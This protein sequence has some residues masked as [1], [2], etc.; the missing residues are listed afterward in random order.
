M[1]TGAFGNVSDPFGGLPSISTTAPKGADFNDGDHGVDEERGAA[2]YSYPIAVPPGRSGMQPSLALT[3]SSQAPLRGGIAVGWTFFNF[4][5]VEV[6]RSR[7]T[8]ELHY[9][10]NGARLVEVDD[11]KGSAVAVYRAAYDAS[12]T[13]WERRYDVDLGEYWIARSLNGSRMEFKKNVGGRQW[14]LTSQIDAYGNRVDYDWGDQ[15][16][17]WANAPSGTPPYLAYELK[18][19]LY[20]ANENTHIAPFARVTFA[21]SDPPRQ[22]G[23]WIP[24][25]AQL[26]WEDGPTLSNTGDA[27]G[28]VMGARQLDAVKTWVKDA[29][30]PSGWRDVQT[31]SLTY[32]F[33]D[34]ERGA[35]LRYLKY[36]DVSARAPCP[37]GTSCQAT[38][39]VAPR[40]TL[41]YGRYDRLFDK[42]HQVNVP[43]SAT[44]PIDSGLAGTAAGATTGF[45]DIDGDGLRDLVRMAAVRDKEDRKSNCTIL[46][47]KGL[48]DGQF[49]PETP[50]A[51]GITIPTMDWL[52]NEL[53]QGGQNSP[54]LGYD[55]NSQEWVQERCTLTGQYALEFRQ[56][57]LGQLQC[58]NEY[59]KIIGYRF[60]DFDNDGQIDLLTTPWRAMALDAPTSNSL[61]NTGRIATD[62][63]CG[64]GL[65]CG[66]A[67]SCVGGF[68]ASPGAPPPTVDCWDCGD[69]GGD[70]GGPGPGHTQPSRFDPETCGEWGTL[71]PP[72]ESISNIDYFVW[73]LLTHDGD[74]H[75]FIYATT[76]HSQLPLPPPGQE[77]LVE[78][79]NGT[80]P[81]T[82]QTL[83]D[84]DDDGVLDILATPRDPDSTAAEEWRTTRV[85]LGAATH[86]AVGL[87]DP[88]MWFRPA[89]FRK[90]SYGHM[91][92]TPG[93][94]PPWNDKPTSAELYSNS[95]IEDINGDGLKDLVLR[96][97]GRKLSYYPNTGKRFAENLIDLGFDVPVQRTHVDATWNSGNLAPSGG[98]RRT[99]FQLFDVDADGRP[100]LVELQQPGDVVRVRYNLGD[101]FSGLKE[102]RSEWRAVTRPVAM[103]EG[104][105]MVI[106]D[107]TD[108]DGDGLPD[109]QG[110]ETISQ[111]PPGGGAGFVNPSNSRLL[112]WQ[113]DDYG[114][115]PPRLLTTIDNGR[116][117]TTYYEYQPNSKLEGA[118]T[119]KPIFVVTRVATVASPSSP[120]ISTT[121]R[122]SRPQY[123]AH[124]VLDPRSTTTIYDDETRAMQFQ[125]F[126]EVE[127][128]GSAPDGEGHGTDVINTYEYRADGRGYLVRQRSYVWDNGAV[129]RRLLHVGL[130]SWFEEPL[131]DGRVSTVRNVVADTRV[132]L[133]SVEADCLGDHADGNFAY[134]GTSTFVRSVLTNG[135]RGLYVPDTVYTYES[136]RSGS[137]V[138]HPRFDLL[139]AAHADD[140]GFDYRVLPT[141]TKVEHVE[142][143]GSQSSAVLISRQMTLYDANHFPTATRQ[144]YGPAENDYV[145]SEQSFDSATGLVLTTKRPEQVKVGAAGRVARYTYDANKVFAEVVINE[146]GYGAHTFYDPGTGAAIKKTGP[147]MVLV[148]NSST[149]TDPTC[150]KSF[151]TEETAWSVDGFGRTLAMAT[152]YQLGDTQT[153]APMVTLSTT[154]YDDI[155]N[156]VTSRSLIDPI[157]ARPRW[158]TSRTRMDGLGRTISQ[159]TC[160][161]AGTTDDSCLADARNA[162]VSYDYDG[163]G[164]MV[165]TTMPN[166]SSD[167]ATV[168]YLFSHD[169]IGRETLMTRPD[170]SAM[171]VE[172]GPLSNKATEAGTI[173]NGGSTVAIS[174]MDGNVT[175]VL[176]CIAAPCETMP[177]ESYAGP[178]WS[179]TLYGYDDF[180]RL[181]SVTDA[182]DDETLMEH[183]LLG[184]RT[185][186]SRGGGTRVWSY[187][188]DL[189]GN[190]LG[191]T[192]PMPAG[193]TDPS[194][195][196]STNT[197][198]AIDRV[199]AHTPAPREATDDQLKQS[200]SLPFVYRYDDAPNGVGRLVSV[201]QPA[202]RPL[203]AGEVFYYNASYAYDGMGRV[204]QETRLMNPGGLVDQGLTQTVSNTFNALGSV[205][206]SVWDDGQTITTSYDD[207]G[208]TQKIT[209]S[210]GGNLGANTIADYGTR[211]R[212]GLPLSRTTSLTFGRVAR[213]WTYDSSGRVLTD[214]IQ[215][216]AWLSGSPFV[217]AQRTYS[218][219]S[220][221][222]LRSVTGK[223]R[224]EGAD[225]E[226]G[227]K[228]LNETFEFD[229]THRVT[230]AH[231]TTTGYN[232][233]LTYNR[234]GNI[235]TANV[236]GLPSET[237]N[238]D[239][240]YHYDWLDKQAVDRLTDRLNDTSVVALLAYT[241]MGEMSSRQWPLGDEQRMDW[242]GD[243]Q[244][245]Q[246][247]TPDGTIERYAYDQNGQR[248]WAAKEN[249]VEAGTRYWFGSSE[250]SIPASGTTGRK[251]SIYIADGGGTLA[252]TERVDNGVTMVELSFADALQDAFLTV[253][254]ITKPDGSELLTT[255]AVVTSWFHYGAFGEVIAQGGESTH[256]RQFNGK[257]SDAASGLRYYGARYYDPLLMKWT[258]ADPLYRFAPEFDLLSP[259]RQNLYS[260]TANNP[261]V[262]ADPDGLDANPAIALIP[263]ASEIGVA[264]VAGMSG[265]LSNVIGR[266]NVAKISRLHTREQATYRAA[267]G[268][269]QAF[270]TPP[271]KVA[272][273]PVAIYAEERGSRVRAIPQEGDAVPAVP[274]GQELVDRAKDI[275]GAIVRPDG[276]PD[277]DAQKHRTTA[278]GVTETGKVV[279]AGSGAK[280]LSADQVKALVPGEI[281][282]NDDRTANKHAEI[283][284]YEWAKAAGEIIGAVAASRPVCAGNGGQPGCQ[285]AG[286]A[287]NPGINVVNPK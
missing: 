177:D 217:E 190:M 279:V 130:N 172:Y 260:F 37:Y 197:Y 99:I 209:F 253:K 95:T 241:P 7:D 183:D 166:P 212:A 44:L 280:G 55:L 107:V 256:R 155:N 236:G 10:V 216:P 214:V 222:E 273:V 287:H 35:Q 252:R 8:T 100:D 125:G 49:G 173:T 81:L 40:I 15:V 175:Q 73:G 3:Y 2:T 187:A 18:Q 218:Y 122:Y 266:S 110:W 119:P 121:Y 80:S 195:Y 267:A 94:F 62:G 220:N 33:S 158:M 29:T 210:G 84:L 268:L 131:F 258:S 61:V 92:S 83:I 223:T 124:V 230:T 247:Q 162:V 170:G 204:K 25:G 150:P 160:R 66:G 32:E 167:A 239:V 196:T 135:K 13:R 270:E 126:Q 50:P 19:I 116:G 115:S 188:Y 9:A 283:K 262:F 192:S 169:S 200:W 139:Y 111:V 14:R 118:G 104:Q 54:S 179:V 72:Y 117:A 234:V 285:Q 205:T 142:G 76:I 161:V 243:G 21:Y 152:T 6:D 93:L 56:S 202:F 22:D 129:A 148:F 286:A 228:N 58:S 240:K 257:E 51:L 103:N 213:S 219:L 85:D 246:V 261:V 284:L 181:I 59:L 140:G 171:R 164:L 259:Q 105:W 250:T 28:V 63:T 101:G 67:L 249:A 231:E 182:E 194:K 120:E 215:R 193:A 78:A 211:N 46:W 244:L 42:S 233:S 53:E 141:E 128:L 89:A 180:G 227:F 199:T 41:S 24:P 134:S 186:I 264:V 70:G 226:T 225:T 221:G 87:G 251:R 265:V 282:V 138:E 235:V 82:L 159:T 20:T 237:E 154:S 1:L 48:G 97:A 276:T 75:R 271:A 208:Q 275:H 178:N 106:G 74:S 98:S 254:G 165:S 31:T 191:E 185:K 34:P 17:I 91:L 145:T 12:F 71:E 36:I 274:Q 133:T 189:D 198:D 232:L 143:N 30:A 229:T 27:T 102:L 45:M 157:E 132:C 52:N 4:P 281:P 149:C 108:V 114:T 184:R 146:I 60:G 112:T 238:R 96:T 255:G 242:D 278:V 147:N 174:D 39:T 88:T 144:W 79:R 11:I 168:T 224:L 277:T 245:R 269:K 109:L 65:V 136:E 263:A 43:S 5:I 68:C 201:G 137:T 151:Q 86:L 38:T 123:G 203:G 57:S 26:K 207:R 90:E 248:I 176:E 163:A 272:V 16:A 23:S 113:T 69:E 127:T 47:S 153:A 156:T 206:R 77:Q 64:D